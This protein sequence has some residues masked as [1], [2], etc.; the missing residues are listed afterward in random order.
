MEAAIEF[1][2]SNYVY[3][4]IFSSIGK[5]FADMESS[6]FLSVS[7][8]QMCLLARERSVSWQEGDLC[9]D[10]REI[11]FL[12]RQRE[13]ERWGPV[14]AACLRTANTA[15]IILWVAVRTARSANFSLI[16]ESTLLYGTCYTDCFIRRDDG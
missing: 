2:R 12:A 10:R 16:K 13:R 8:R 11:C 9:A 15:K 14:P 7:K 4:Q 6:D 3:T 1:L 5:N